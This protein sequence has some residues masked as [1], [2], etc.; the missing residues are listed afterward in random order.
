M[1]W[2]WFTAPHVDTKRS[3]P[4]LNRLRAEIPLLMNIET[5][6]A[7][8]IAPT[9]TSVTTVSKAIKVMIGGTVYYVPAYATFS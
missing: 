5:A 4:P 9:A 6:P 3:A 8:T 7:A 1:N 2:D